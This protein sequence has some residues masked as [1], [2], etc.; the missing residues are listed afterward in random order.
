MYVGLKLITTEAMRDNVHSEKLHLAQ[1]DFE[2]RK[3]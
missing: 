1:N 2:L 3:R